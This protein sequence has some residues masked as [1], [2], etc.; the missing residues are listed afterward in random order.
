MAHGAKK[1]GAERGHLP[2]P[3]RGALKE[4]VF[5]HPPEKRVSR[6]GARSRSAPRNCNS[7]TVGRSGP[8]EV[9]VGG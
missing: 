1:H 7:G 4:R 2:K 3:A 5:T 9:F 8:V 6:P